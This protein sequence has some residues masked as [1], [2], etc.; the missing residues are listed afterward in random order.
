ME[1]LFN[2]IPSV[3]DKDKCN[4]VEGEDNLQTTTTG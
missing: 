2:E 3:G 4:T 1:R